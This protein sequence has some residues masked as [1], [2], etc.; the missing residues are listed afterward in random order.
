MI[1][2]EGFFKEEQTPIK[3]RIQNVY[4]PKT[5]KHIAR[6]NNKTNDKEL[7]KMMVNPNYFID[8]NLKIGFKIYLESHNLSHA[9]SIL[10]NIPNFPELGIEIR[11]TIKI[12]K[13][14]S[15][16]YAKLIKQ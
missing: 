8:E 4:N 7:A 9:N 5:S 15:V 11:Y 3:E 14:L 10:T 16:I 12:M 6:E 2:P 13:G 1:I